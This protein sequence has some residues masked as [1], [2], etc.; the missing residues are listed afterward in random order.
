MKQIIIIAVLFLLSSCEV[1]NP[2]MTFKIIGSGTFSIA[3]SDDGGSSSFNGSAQNFT[4]EMST[5]EFWALSAQSN[6]GTGVK[7]EAYVGTELVK[8]QSASGYGIA[9]IYGTY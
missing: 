8:T 4:R 1:F 7:V 3:F 9:S 5:D 6:N 2:T